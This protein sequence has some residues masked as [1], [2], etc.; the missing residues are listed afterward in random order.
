ME[1]DHQASIIEMEG[2]LYDQVFSILIETI[3]NYSY[4]SPELVD[5]CILN[6]KLH[7]ESCL[8]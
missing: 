1:E 2:K 8:V 5:K 3:S 6:K 7:E 4:V